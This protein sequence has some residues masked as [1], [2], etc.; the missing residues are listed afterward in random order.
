MNETFK[1]VQTKT[2]EIWET[3]DDN[4]IKEFY[5]TVLTPYIKN[6]NRIYGDIMEEYLNDIQNFGLNKNKL[7]DT[8]VQQIYSQDIGECIAPYKLEK[9]KETENAIM[10]LALPIKQVNNEPQFR[11][12]IPKSSISKDGTIEDW[13]IKEKNLLFV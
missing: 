7:T 2:Y 9:Y 6:G 4:K 8:L 12:W 3:E 11:V 1:A 10:F 5:E 13:V